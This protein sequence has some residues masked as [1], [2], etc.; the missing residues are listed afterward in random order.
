[1]EAKSNIGILGAGRMLDAREAQE[2]LA[3]LRKE[4]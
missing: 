3:E 4:N 2:K 1:M